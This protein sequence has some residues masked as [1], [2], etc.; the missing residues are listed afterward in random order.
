MDWKDV[1]SWLETNAGA[2]AALVG[3]LL[4]GN[5][6]GAIAPG[7][8]PIDRRAGPDAGRMDFARAA[9]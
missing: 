7:H 4:T 3:S 8:Q 6:P 1:G 2:G 9:R 5:V